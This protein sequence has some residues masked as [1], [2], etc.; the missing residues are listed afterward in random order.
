MVNPSMDDGRL[1]ISG[2]GRWSIVPCAPSNPIPRCFYALDHRHRTR[3]R[4]AYAHWVTV[5]EGIFQA[6]LDRVHAQRQLR[7]SQGR[8]I[9]DR[10]RAPMQAP[11][12]R[13][14]LKIPGPPRSLS[15]PLPPS[16]VS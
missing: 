9:V 14:F 13:E 4:R 5:F 8:R 2:F 11:T 7:R 15:L 3:R 16:S 6:E 1:T 12:V 10:G